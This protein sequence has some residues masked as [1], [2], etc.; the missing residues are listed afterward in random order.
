V[1]GFF[2]RFLEGGK[3]MKTIRITITTPEPVKVEFIQNIRKP[4]TVEQKLFRLLRHLADE[5]SR[6]AQ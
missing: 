2:R 1:R 6:T 3:A 5:E 4:E